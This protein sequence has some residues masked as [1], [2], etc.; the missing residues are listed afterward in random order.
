LLYRILELELVP[1]YTYLGYGFLVP[2][3]I[4]I[5]SGENASKEGEVRMNFIV[6]KPENAATSSR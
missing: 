3:M 4:L 2:G 5:L 6:Y 1:A